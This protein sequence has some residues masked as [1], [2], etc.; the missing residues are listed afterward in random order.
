MTILRIGLTLLAGLLIG[1]DDPKPMGDVEKAIEGVW[2]VKEA[3]RGGQP[4]EKPVGDEVSIRDGQITIAPDE[5]GGR[6]EMA[7]YTLDTSKD[8]KQIDFKPGVEGN[9]GE[10]PPVLQGIFKVEGDTL[11]IVLAGP[12]V[13]RPTEFKTSEGSTTLMAVLKRQ[14]E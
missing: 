9:Q 10:E 2:V 13:Q 11:T 3:E 5:D 6:R 4:A 14:A 12:G 8:P 1:A 7:T